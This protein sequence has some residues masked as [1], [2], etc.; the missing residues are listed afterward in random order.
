M[1]ILILL[2]WFLLTFKDSYENKLTP[3]Q[4]RLK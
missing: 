2:N 1:V 4:A 3:L